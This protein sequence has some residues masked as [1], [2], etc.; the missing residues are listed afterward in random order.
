MDDNKRQSSLLKTFIFECEH[1]Y[2]EQQSAITLQL[3][4]LFASLSMDTELIYTAK[5]YLA[6]QYASFDSYTDQLADQPTEYMCNVRVDLSSF[7]AIFY[8]CYS[9][10]VADDNGIVLCS[11]CFQRGTRVYRSSWY[12]V[13]TAVIPRYLREKLGTAY[14]PRKHH[15]VEHEKQ[16]ITFIQTLSL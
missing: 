12:H 2:T 5:Q 1:A 14:K 3:N 8:R 15:V 6:A 13:N 11:E 10:S 7:G 4:Q 9:C 16:S